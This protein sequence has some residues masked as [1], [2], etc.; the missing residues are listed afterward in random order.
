[1]LQ[2]YC[3]LICVQIGDCCP[4]T[5]GACDG[6]WCCQS[7]PLDCPAVGKEYDGP[8]PPGNAIFAEDWANPSTAFTE[9]VAPGFTN[10]SVALNVRQ[11]PNTAFALTQK[12]GGC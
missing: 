9:T 6:I 3:D 12:D 4:G 10:N 1:M 5:C 11:Y 8:P 7:P 2:C